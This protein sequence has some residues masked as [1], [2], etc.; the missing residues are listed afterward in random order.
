MSCCLL[1]SMGVWH[2]VTLALSCKDCAFDMW[3]RTLQEALLAMAR[4]FGF[5]FRKSLLARIRLAC[6]CLIWLA[7]LKNYNKNELAYIWVGHSQVF[8][9]HHGPGWAGNQGQG[10]KIT[11]NIR[12]QQVD[13]LK[14]QNLHWTQNREPHGLPKME[15]WL[16]AHECERGS[17][18]GSTCSA[19]VSCGIFLQQR[20]F[21]SIN[22][23]WFSPTRGILPSAHMQRALWLH[24]FQKSL[25]M[26]ELWRVVSMCFH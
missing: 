16:L 11:A 17:V 14:I 3:Q 1:L 26:F 18:W 4:D 10:N 5:F 24:R 9:I 2:F 13:L 22:L 20:N 8:C 19:S 6:C 7:H 23:P 25:G 12:G 21:G 15:N